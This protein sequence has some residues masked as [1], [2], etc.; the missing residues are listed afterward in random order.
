MSDNLARNYA[1][2]SFGEV[3]DIPN[4]EYEIPF[5]QRGYVWDSE[6]WVELLEE[7][8]LESICDVSDPSIKNDLEKIKDMGEEEIKDVNYYFGTIYLKKK[9]INNTVGPSTPTRYL[10]I[11]GQQRLITIY[12]FLVR[13]YYSLDREDSYQGKIVNYRKKIFNDTPG[14]KSK[15][16]IYTLKLD[17]QDLIAIITANG[18]FNPNVRG[19]IS[20]FNKWYDKRVN[21]ISTESKYKL[22]IILFYSLKITEITLSEEDDEMLIFENLNDKGTPLSGDELLCNYI[23]QPVI[24]DEQYNEEKIKE[25]HSK[26]WLNSYTEIQQMKIETGGRRVSTSEQYLFFLRTILSIGKNKMIGRDKDI[27]YTFKKSYPNPNSREMVDVLEN[28]N[29][30]VLLFKRS[31]QPR[32][33]RI[34]NEQI[35]S[36]ELV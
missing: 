10:I 31:I 26:Y 35:I 11:D 15:S 36:E 29:N 14:Y 2:K 32:E 23:F 18:Q 7:V 22:F 5:F 17:E 24:R 4:V 12:L 28:I 20:E 30:H 27:Y 6:K 34:S 19:Q 13:L 33:Y 1:E 21:T 8:V 16:K 25:L 3:F 9:P